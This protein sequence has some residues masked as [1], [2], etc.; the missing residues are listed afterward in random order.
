MLITKL[1][2]AVAVVFAIAALCGGVVVEPLLAQ[3]KREQ[4][5][6][7]Q[8]DGTIKKIEGN[9]VTITKMEKDKKVDVTLAAHEKAKIIAQ[10]ADKLKFGDIEIDVDPAQ[11]QIEIDGTK[12]ELDEKFQFAFPNGFKG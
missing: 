12:V 6:K 5:K 7:N 4:D 11:I 2:I 3:Q 9:K 1:K 8:F 10:F